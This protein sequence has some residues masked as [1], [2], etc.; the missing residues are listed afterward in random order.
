KLGTFKVPTPPNVALL[1]GARIAPEASVTVLPPPIVPEPARVAPPAT[2]TPLLAI[3][4]APLP[5]V[6]ALLLAVTSPATVPVPFQLP[7]TEFSVTPMVPPERLIAPLPERTALPP[8]LP[9]PASVAALTETVLAE[10]SEPLTASVPP[11]LT[12]KLP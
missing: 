6:S 11:P 8:T 10:D 9:E 5:I 12:S 4:V 7:P 1:P 2:F 3:K